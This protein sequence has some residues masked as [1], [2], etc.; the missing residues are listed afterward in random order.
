[1]KFKTRYLIT[2]VMILVALSLAACDGVSGGVSISELTAGLESS[3][4]D[5]PETNSQAFDRSKNELASISDAGSTD[6][7]G[8]S[9]ADKVK[10]YG[11]VEDVTENTISF[12]GET[13]TVDTTQDLTALFQA[14]AH[15]EIEYRLNADGS[16][17]L[18]DFHLDDNGSSDDYLKFYGIVEDV[19]ENTI[20]FNGE[21][22][23]VDTSEDLTTL[24]EIG[25]FYEIKYVMNANGTI[26]IIDFH[27]EDD[28]MGDDDFG[29]FSDDDMDDDNDMDDDMNDDDNDEYNDNN[30][31]NDNNYN[32]DDN[33]ND[34]DNNND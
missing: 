19:T 14:G 29:D 16:I 10:F 27:L 18:L 24:F 20:T 11:V 28:G 34:N 23:T 13:F 32:N 5:N 15:F 6:F 7:S 22:F 21:P 17:T 9:L 4:A 1:M 30:D 3:S 12:N 26:S 33:N 8:T 31:Y 2:A 25:A